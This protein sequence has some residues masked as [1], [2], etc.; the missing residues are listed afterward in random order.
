[1]SDS[2]S[3]VMYEIDLPGGMNIRMSGTLM[4]VNF[5]KAKKWLLSYDKISVIARNPAAA[6]L[7]LTWFATNSACNVFP[8]FQ[9]KKGHLLYFAMQNYKTFVNNEAISRQFTS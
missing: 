9:Q 2:G 6:A 3:L 5:V 1:M 4:D 8:P 7:I